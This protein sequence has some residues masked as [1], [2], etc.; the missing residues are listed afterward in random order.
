M[1]RPNPDRNNDAMF[2]REYKLCKDCGA[3]I[4]INHWQCE[5]CAEKGRAEMAEAMAATRRRQSVIDGKLAQDGR[6][7]K[8]GKLGGK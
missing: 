1:S 7:H 4:P 6:D 5:S 3:S 8:H 2:S